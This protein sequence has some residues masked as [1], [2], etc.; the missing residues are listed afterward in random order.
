MWDEKARFRGGAVASI[1]SA[2]VMS[3]S[4][5]AEA[6]TDDHFLHA[7]CSKLCWLLDRSR[8][9]TWMVGKAAPK[10]LRSNH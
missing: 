7:A 1:A 8:C 9:A 10:A 4:V 2:L 5:Q 3:L 6:Q